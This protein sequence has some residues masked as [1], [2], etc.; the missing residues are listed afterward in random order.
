MS[1]SDFNATVLALALV[2]VA[3]AAFVLWFGL[4][5][6]TVLLPGGIMVIGIIGSAWGRWRR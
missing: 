3:A 4:P 6:W 1:Q 5:L 2:V